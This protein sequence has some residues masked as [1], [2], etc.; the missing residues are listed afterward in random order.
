MLNQRQD[1]NQPAQNNYLSQY[2]Q[3]SNL[4]SIQIG[5]YIKDK[6]K[7]HILLELPF[8]K[9]LLLCFRETKEKRD[10]C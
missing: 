8:G 6:T 10:G 7:K 1:W 3:N 9:S 5:R 4:H 2:Q